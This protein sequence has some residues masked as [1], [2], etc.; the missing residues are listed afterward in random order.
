MRSAASDFLSAGL[1][2]L[3]LLC[4]MSDS[5]RAGREDSLR[6]EDRGQRRSVEKVKRGK[7]WWLNQMV[8]GRDV[9]NAKTE[10]KERYI[11]AN[12]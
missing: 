7:Y 6:L 1:N 3:L 2:F 8:E 9:R 11:K 12:V 5:H 10:K 4:S